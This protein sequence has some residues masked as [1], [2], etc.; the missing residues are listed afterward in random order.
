MECSDTLEYH[1]ADIKEEQTAIV[2]CNG[3]VLY[4]CLRISANE[5]QLLSN[6]LGKIGRW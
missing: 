2:V 3:V 6:A 4:F 1:K 5:I